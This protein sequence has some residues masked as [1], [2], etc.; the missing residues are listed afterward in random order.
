LG[1]D[2]RSAM[3][4]PKRSSEYS[5]MHLNLYRVDLDHAVQVV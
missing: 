2:G 5:S 1:S 3:P 4:A